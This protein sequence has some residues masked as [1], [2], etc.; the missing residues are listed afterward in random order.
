MPCFAPERSRLAHI[1]SAVHGKKTCQCSKFPICL[2]CTLLGLHGCCN[3]QSSWML[4]Q[5]AACRQL[6]DSTEMCCS[7]L[8]SLRQG[9]SLTCDVHNRCKV[10]FDVWK[11]PN[12]CRLWRQLP[13]VAQL[14]HCSFSKSKLLGSACCCWYYA[15]CHSRTLLCCCGAA[16]R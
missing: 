2:P 5:A 15:T 8:T 12:S 16:D 3:I 4:Q 7:C 6:P 14:D 1:T 10:A 11:S 13:A 9:T